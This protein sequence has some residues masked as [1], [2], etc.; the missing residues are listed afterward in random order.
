MLVRRLTIL[1]TIVLALSAFSLR[2]Q[3][4]DTAE[5]IPPPRTIETTV[6]QYA[7]GRLYFPVGEESLVYPQASLSLIVDTTEVLTSRIEHSWLGMSASYPLTGL[8]DTLDPAVLW[9]EIQA[10]DVDSLSPTIIGTDIIGLE[11]L[12]RQSDLS[13]AM[14]REYAY[15]PAMIDALNDG[16]LDAVLSFKSLREPPGGYTRSSPAPFIAA[17]I[18][19]V[20][21]DCNAGGQLTTSLYY[22]FDE[23]KLPLV[24]TGEDARTQYGFHVHEREGQRT[25]LTRWYPFD[26]ARGR[27]LFANVSKPQN[28]VSIYYG[29]ES[30]ERPAYF[31][32]DILS[33]DRCRISL[34]RD[35][36]EADVYVE[37]LPVSQNIPSVTMY[38]LHH[39]FVVDSVAGKL[40]N[41]SV[42]QMA[43]YFRFVENPPSEDEYYRNL[44]AAE[45]VAIDDLGAFPLFRPALHLAAHKHLREVRFDPSGNLDLSAMYRV[46]LPGHRLP[47]VTQ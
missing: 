38:A 20:G 30:L 17:L 1:S 21:R 24:F 29:N 42:R 15:R 8:L 33:R 22:R 40:P 9:A 32:A 13:R 3:P 26:P 12:L 2:A 41:E 6:L 7:H 43:A 34:T 5:S 46:V 36:R 10:A 11:D 45:L 25:S 31:F 16:T 23:A 14:I 39:R 47:E 18:P 19:H 37:F 35:R 27:A 28:R 44:E 4:V